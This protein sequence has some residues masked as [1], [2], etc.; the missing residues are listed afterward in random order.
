MGYSWRAGRGMGNGA[1]SR[2]NQYTGTTFSTTACSLLA[3][4]V[5]TSVNKGRRAGPMKGQLI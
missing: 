3:G 4:N 2:G 1:E 5:T